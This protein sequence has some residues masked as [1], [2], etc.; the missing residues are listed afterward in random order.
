MCVCVCVCVIKE[1][2]LCEDEGLYCPNVSL[3]Y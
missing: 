2:S 1:S 3:N